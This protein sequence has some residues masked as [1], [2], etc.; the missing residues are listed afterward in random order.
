MARFSRAIADPGDRL[1]H[2][3]EIR[4]ALSRHFGGEKEMRK[5]LRLTDAEWSDLGRIANHE[6]IQESRHRG[7]HPALRPATEEERI[8]VIEI[9]RRMLRVY[10]DHL[11]RTPTV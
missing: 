6:P 7:K 2:L 1:T 10:L 11:D 8:R 4:D 5:A 9:T 3:Y